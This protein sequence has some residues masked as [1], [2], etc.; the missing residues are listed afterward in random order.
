MVIWRAVIG[1]FKAVFLLDNISIIQVNGIFDKG[2]EVRIMLITPYVR[3]F[4]DK[5]PGRIG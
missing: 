2:V 5:S 4:L 1:I 3:A